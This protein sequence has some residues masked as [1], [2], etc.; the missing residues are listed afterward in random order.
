MCIL[1]LH[2]LVILEAFKVMKPL[3]GLR[4]QSNQSI[5]LNTITDCVS[6][7]FT[8]K[9]IAGNICPLRRLCDIECKIGPWI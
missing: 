2:V 8:E 5:M 1:L 3:K 7:P 6:H 4:A 9:Q